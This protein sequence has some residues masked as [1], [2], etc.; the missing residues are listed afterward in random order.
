MKTYGRKQTIVD[1]IKK[2]TLRLLGHRC[3]MNGNNLG[4]HVLFMKIKGKPYRD[5]PC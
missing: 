5:H 2:R 1:I 4:K 3:Q